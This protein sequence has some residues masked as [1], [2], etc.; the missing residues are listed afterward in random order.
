MWFWLSIKITTLKINKIVKLSTIVVGAAEIFLFNNRNFIV[1][2]KSKHTL[3]I[4][5]PNKWKWVTRMKLFYIWK[6]EIRS[7]CINFQPQLRKEKLYSSQIKF[8]D[9]IIDY[10]YGL[11][12]KFIWKYFQNFTNNLDSCWFARTKFYGII[13]AR[14]SFYVFNTYFILL[15]VLLI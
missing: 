4:S 13:F 14:G 8:S 2:E 10:K 5:L 6:L 7:L 15:L 11:S 9:F 3:L 12:V 1:W